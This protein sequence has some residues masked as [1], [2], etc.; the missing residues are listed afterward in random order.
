MK[1]P[2]TWQDTQEQQHLP[3]SQKLQKLK[4]ESEMVVSTWHATTH[5]CVRLLITVIENPI[6]IEHIAK[7]NQKIVF[8]IASENLNSSP[9]LPLL[10]FIALSPSAKGLRNKNTSPSQPKKL[11]I[12]KIKSKMVVSA[13][14][15]VVHICARLLRTMILDSIPTKHIAKRSQKLAFNIEY[16]NGHECRSKVLKVKC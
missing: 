6:P 9:L 15:A 11:Q 16:K 7:R 2:V 8:S 1:Y 10:G 5:I 13:A 3:G 4:A 12:L 14:P